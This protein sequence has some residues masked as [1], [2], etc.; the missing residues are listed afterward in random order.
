MITQTEIKGTL[1]SIALILTAA[2]A[3]FLNTSTGFWNGII[4]LT[5]AVGVVVLREKLK[6]VKESIKEEEKV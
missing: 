3:A 5:F 4:C 6:S 1:L 2:G